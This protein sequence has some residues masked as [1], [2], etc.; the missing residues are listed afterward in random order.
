M[1][2]GTNNDATRALHALLDG[3]DG[4]GP[5]ARAAR[6]AQDDELADFLCGVQDDIV[7]EARK[8]LAQRAAE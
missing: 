5:A 3:A 1:T 6:L 2:H 8:L 7:G 4:C